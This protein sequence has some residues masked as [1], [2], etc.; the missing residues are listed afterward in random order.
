M[1]NVCPFAKTLNVNQVSNVQMEDAFQY[2][3]FAPHQ[4]NANRHKYAT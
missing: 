4:D 1:A 2:L 3:V